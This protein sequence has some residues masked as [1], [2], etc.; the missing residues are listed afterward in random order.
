MTQWEKANMD[1]EHDFKLVESIEQNAHHYIE[2]FSRAVD[3]VLPAP[4]KEPK[5]DEQ[6]PR[7]F[8]LLL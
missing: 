2:T 6:I 1:D 4:S 7:L 5:Y 3:K 8:K